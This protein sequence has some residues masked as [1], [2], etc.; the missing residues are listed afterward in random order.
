MAIAQSR[1]ISLINAAL[2]YKQ[3]LEQLIDSIFASSRAAQNNPSQASALL[4]DLTTLA[5]IRALLQ[6]PESLTTLALEYHHF[7]RNARRN[8]RLAERQSLLRRD[9]GAIPRST[10]PRDATLA[11][12]PSLAFAASLKRPSISI[13]PTYANISP[14]DR[15]AIEMEAQITADRRAA[16]CPHCRAISLDDCPSRSTC[17]WTS[18]ILS[19]QQSE[20]DQDDV[21]SL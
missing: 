12:A 19:Q 2:D 6:N 18:R 7:R 11:N 8:N 1:M 15:A 21:D 13:S 9:A 10:T 3:A 4:S 16:E 14:A 17:Q 20:A 5:N